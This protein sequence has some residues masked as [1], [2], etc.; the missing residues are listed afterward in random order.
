MSGCRGNGAQRGRNCRAD[1]PGKQHMCLTD[2]LPY[3]GLKRLMKM[4]TNHLSREYLRTIDFKLAAWS[5]YWVPLALLQWKIIINI[6]YPLCTG[7]S[8][9]SSGFPGCPLPEPVSY[10]HFLQ[11]NSVS[12]HHL[13][14]TV[15]PPIFC[16]QDAECHGFIK[17][18]NSVSFS[19]LF[20]MFLPFIL[21][22][23][24]Q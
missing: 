19:F 23:W 21:P 16:I 24:S 2:S 15:T 22:F 18:Q 14:N 4:Q 12:F 8:L 1:C 5:S 9:P 20:L 10:S 7:V 13:G 6:H 17:L 11:H 3:G